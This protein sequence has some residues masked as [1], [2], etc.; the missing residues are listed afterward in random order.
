M[1]R[2]RRHRTGAAMAMDVEAVA[3]D[4]VEAGEGGIE[5]FA[6]IFGEAGAVALD[7]AILRAA[8]FAED[9]DWIVELRRPDHG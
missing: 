7:E 3:A 9:I 1:Y 6:E 8:Q 5:F 4:P 2:R